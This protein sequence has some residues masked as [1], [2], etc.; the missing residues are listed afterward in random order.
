MTAQSTKSAAAREQYLNNK[1]HK[2][3]KKTEAIL[4]IWGGVDS[5]ANI[6]RNAEHRRLDTLK[7]GKGG[8]PPSEAM[9]FV[10]TL[11][12]GI[13]PSQEQW[14]KMCKKVVTDIAAKLNIHPREF[15]G[16]ARAVVHQQ[17]QTGSKGS[18]DHMHL[19]MGKFT[20]SKKYLPDLQRKGVLHTIKVSFNAAVRD[21][22]GVDHSTYEANKN[23][24]GVAKKKAPQWKVKAARER[25]ALNEKEQQLNQKN[26]DLGMKEMDLYF[27]GADLE[28]REK[29][30]GKQTKY[31]TMLAKLGIYLK[32]LDDAFVEGNERQYKRQLNRANKQI[33]EIAQEE[34]AAFIDTPELQA[35]T[36]NI[37]QKIERFNEQ[38]GE[39]LKHIP[40]D[41]KKAPK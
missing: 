6:I 21:V 34:E 17:E 33:R 31:T 35:A 38:S 32:K 3:H 22:M 7:K 28:E 41:T 5:T 19:M 1:N 25:E 13:R 12:K 18:G 15:N 24:E 30:L 10:L 39:K 2:N 4:N 11:P 9:E 23:Y 8:R 20:N 26:N 37:N 27:K 29:E 40:I 16:V 14:Q 36:Q